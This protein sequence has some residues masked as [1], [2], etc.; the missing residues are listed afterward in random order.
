[1]SKG[2]ISQNGCGRDHW[3]DSSQ[4]RSSWTIVIKSSHR[5]WQVLGQHG[6]SGGIVLFIWVLILDSSEMRPIQA[7]TYWRSYQFLNLTVR[8]SGSRTKWRGARGLPSI[9]PAARI[10]TISSLFPNVVAENTSPC[11]IDVLVDFGLL[12]ATTTASPE[13]HRR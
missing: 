2:T 13:G 1:M 7:S 3:I 5:I 10:F 11:N 9:D 4:L 12:C 6:L 8:N